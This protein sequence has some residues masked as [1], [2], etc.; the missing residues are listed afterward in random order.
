MCVCK[1]WGSQGVWSRTPGMLGRVGQEGAE[2]VQVQLGTVVV[3]HILV[4]AVSNHGPQGSMCMMSR[5]SHA[6][7]GLMELEASSSDSGPQQENTQL[8]PATVLPDPQRGTSL[9]E[10]KSNVCV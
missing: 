8:S 6:L 1:R 7:Q 2:Q 4:R 9:L 5:Q 10:T 3:G